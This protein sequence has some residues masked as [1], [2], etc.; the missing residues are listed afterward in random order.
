MR[1]L[2]ILLLC[3][4]SSIPFTVHKKQEYYSASRFTGTVIQEC[5]PVLNVCQFG[6]AI[7]G[8]RNV[9]EVFVPWGTTL[10]WEVNQVS[11][12]EQV[13]IEAVD[14]GDG[15]FVLRSLKEIP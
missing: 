7:P 5:A 8:E 14:R 13:T 2:W 15:M 1:I 10:Y 6:I 12:Y 4:C 9:R 3:G 11:I